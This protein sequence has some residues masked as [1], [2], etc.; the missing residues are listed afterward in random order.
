[1][2]TVELALLLPFICFL[3]AVAV[4]YARIFYF[5]VIVDNCARN[6]AYYA[7]DYPN[8]DYV[9]NN[10]Y[11]YAN[12][13]DAV[14]RDASNLSPTPTYTV[15]YGSSPNGPFTSSTKP[16]SGYVQITVNWTFYTLTGLPGIP[17]STQLSSSSVMEIAPALPTFPSN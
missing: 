6:G 8:N 3:I 16:A 14:L 15:N 5:A 13:D 10:I 1:V 2:A 9:Y 4:D 7:S 12:L 17:S 11:G